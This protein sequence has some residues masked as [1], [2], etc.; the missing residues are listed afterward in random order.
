VSTQNDC[1]ELRIF[2]RGWVIWQLADIEIM[3]RRNASVTAMV[4]PVF[5]ICSAWQ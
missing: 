2:A 3:L 5:P 4:Q 1:C